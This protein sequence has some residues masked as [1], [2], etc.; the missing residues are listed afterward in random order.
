MLDG[1]VISSPQVETTVQCNVGI[2][3]G[4]DRITGDF[5]QE[6]ADQLAVLIKGGALPVPVAVI[7]SSTVGPTLGEEAIDGSIRAG[8][9]GLSLTAIFLIVV[10]RFVGFLAAV[11]SRPTA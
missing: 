6:E 2:Q 9:I 11:R 7:A 4:G 3:G 5:T 1:G 8:I 10:Y